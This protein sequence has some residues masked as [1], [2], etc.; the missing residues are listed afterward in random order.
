MTHETSNFSPND[1]TNTH[2][3]TRTLTKLNKSLTFNLSQILKC[4]SICCL[5]R[6]M[7]GMG[8]QMGWGCYVWQEVFLFGRGQTLFALSHRISHATA[9]VALAAA[10]AGKN[11]SLHLLGLKS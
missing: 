1:S 5:A 8:W 9:V 7:D 4:D 3:Y 11:S 10:V 6:R 2:S